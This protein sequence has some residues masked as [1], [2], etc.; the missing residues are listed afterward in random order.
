MT[1]EVVECSK[2]SMKNSSGTIYCS[3]C[4]TR[5]PPSANL[6]VSDA[7]LWQHFV[8]PGVTRQQ[9]AAMNPERVS[10]MVRYRRDHKVPAEIRQ[11]SLSTDEIANRIRSYA[12]SIIAENVEGVILERLL[13][14]MEAQTRYL[15]S[16]NTVAQ[17]FGLLLILG[18]VAGCLMVAFGS[19]LQ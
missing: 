18:I 13:A 11:L 14:E 7:V 6:D 4:G 12:G 10:K 19:L 16:I 5:L 3:N 9:V 17:L 2:C 1:N 15:K 8:S